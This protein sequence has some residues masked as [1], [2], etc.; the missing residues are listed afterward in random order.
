MPVLQADGQPIPPALPALPLP[1]R[2][3]A[4]PRRWTGVGQLIASSDRRTAGGTVP[5]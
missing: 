2:M 5:G 3:M 1:R 4:P